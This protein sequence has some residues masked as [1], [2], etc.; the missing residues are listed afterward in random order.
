[1]SQPVIHEYEGNKFYIHQA[2][3]FEQAKFL[4]NLNKSLN[5]FKGVKMDKEIEVAFSDLLRNI[6]GDSVEKLITDTLGLGKIGLKTPED[7]T[8]I[9][10]KTNSGKVD[11]QKLLAVYGSDL[12]GLLSLVV[13]VLKVN[14]ESFFTN[15]GNLLG[16]V[17]IGQVTNSTSAE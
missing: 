1:M 9:N 16:D 2:N 17:G 6:D 4:G 7:D 11:N 3:A 10:I 12:S 8:P 5:G 13:K 15:L 14:F